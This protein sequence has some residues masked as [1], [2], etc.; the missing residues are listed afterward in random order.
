MC[1]LGTQGTGKSGK[2][3]VF[4]CAVAI[5]YK[6]VFVYQVRSRGVY[7]RT[8]THNRQNHRNTTPVYIP[9]SRILGQRKGKKSSWCFRSGSVEPLVRSGGASPLLSRSR[10]NSADATRDSTSGSGVL[11]P[12]NSVEAFGTRLNSRRP[13]ADVLSCAHARASR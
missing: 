13:V 11:R 4:V 12:A 7:S 8:Q 10:P 2:T 3:V 6:G 1:Y 9:P 5:M